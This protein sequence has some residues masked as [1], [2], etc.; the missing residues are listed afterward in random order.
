MPWIPP[1]VAIAVSAPVTVAAAH[2]IFQH[3]TN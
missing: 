3:L 1:I 2:F